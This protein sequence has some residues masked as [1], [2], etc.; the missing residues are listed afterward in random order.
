MRGQVVTTTCAT[1]HVRKWLDLPV[2][3]DSLRL[4]ASLENSRISLHKALSDAPPAS[5]IQVAVGPEGD[6]FG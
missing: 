3:D 6:F 1:D 5:T 2:S 4:V